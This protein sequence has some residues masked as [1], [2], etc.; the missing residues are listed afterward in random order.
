M[1][2]MSNRNNFKKLSDK[3]GLS[4]EDFE[5]YYEYELAEKFNNL[6]DNK[7]KLTIEYGYDCDY[8]VIGKDP[9]K[10]DDKKTM[11][12]NKKDIRNEISEITN[13]V[14]DECGWHRDCFMD[15]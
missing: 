5:T 6:I 2:V 8:I 9:M 3:L 7:S 11:E 14:F 4:E 12:D 1:D 13:G 15:N 10:F